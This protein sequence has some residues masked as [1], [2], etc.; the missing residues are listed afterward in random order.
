[1]P[2]E[3]SSKSEAGNYDSTRRLL[4]RHG[5]LDAAH[6]STASTEDLLR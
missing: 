4:E 3:Y 6:T 2:F 5:L 1:M